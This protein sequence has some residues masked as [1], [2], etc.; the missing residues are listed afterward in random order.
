MLNFEIVGLTT[1]YFIK[2]DLKSCIILSNYLI[3]NR[4]EYEF[5]SYS[6]NEYSIQIKDITKREKIRKALLKLKGDG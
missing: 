5:S 2:L 4:V 1:G 3:K 6:D